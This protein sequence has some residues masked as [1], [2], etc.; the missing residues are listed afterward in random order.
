MR[1]IVFDYIFYEN[2]CQKYTEHRHTKIPEVHRIVGKT[3]DE[4]LY[5][6]Y[7]RLHKESRYTRQY[8][9]YQTQYNDESVFADVPLTPRKKPHIV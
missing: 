4:I 7:E 2:R 9:Y 5:Q 1:N 3:Y 6:V 8:A